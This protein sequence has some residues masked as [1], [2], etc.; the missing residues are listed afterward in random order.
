MDDEKINCGF[1]SA[2]RAFKENPTIE[3]YV[4]LRKK[5]P[6]EI[7]Q[8]AI[9][10]SLE[11][12]WG[13]QDI[14]A[15]FNIPVSLLV[16]VLDADLDAISDL[17]LLLLQRIIERKEIVSSGQTH[18]ISRGLVISDGLIN[19]LVNMML[20]AL[21]WNDNLELPR[22]L[23]VLLRERIGGE[24]S[25]WDKKRKVDDQKMKAVIA[26]MEIYGSGEVPSYRKIAEKLGVNAT[27]VMRWWSFDKE[28]FQKLMNLARHEIQSSQK[29]N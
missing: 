7:V 18:A 4:Y 24:V 14:L 13:N 22:D 26:V 17:S 2:S 8:V 5:Y 28:V 29:N 9:S 23:I 25:D 27:T 3:N 11:W 16:D 6:N 10:S 21:D 19:Y 12:V 15:T 1:N 20:D